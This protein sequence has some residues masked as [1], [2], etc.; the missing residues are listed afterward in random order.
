MKLTKAQRRELQYASDSGGINGGAGL[1]GLEAHR[2]RCTMRYLTNRGLMRELRLGDYELT[3][4]GRAALQAEQVRRETVEAC[5]EVAETTY[6]KDAFHFE[7]GTACAR[8]IR[9]LSDRKNEGGAG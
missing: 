1:H 3:D 7:L 5:A 8:A 2:W 9:A 4:V 6:A